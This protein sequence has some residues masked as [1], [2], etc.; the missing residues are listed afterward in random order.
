MQWIKNRSIPMA[1]NE[2]I[3]VICFGKEIGT[4]GMDVDK[5]VSYFQY[6]PKIY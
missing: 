1:K 2:V 4:I 5:A 6:H 3:K